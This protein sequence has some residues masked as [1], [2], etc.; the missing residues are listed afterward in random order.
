[1][2]HDLS[3]LISVH[4]LLHYEI[5][6]SQQFNQYNHLSPQ[7]IEHENTT[8]YLRQAQRWD[9]NPPLLITGSMTAIHM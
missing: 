3:I 1:M 2:G 4:I 8:A 6:D 7:L 5:K 9:H